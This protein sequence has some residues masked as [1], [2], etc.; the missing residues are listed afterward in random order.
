MSAAEKL[1]Q[2][3]EV[4]CDTSDREEWLRLRVDG[5]GA[6]EISM[7][8]G[9]APDAW[10][11]AVSLYAQK[12]GAYE[13]NLDD[14]EAVFWGNKLEL[15]IIE[16][17]QERTGRRTRKEGFLLR[18]KLYPWALCT[19]DGRT[20]EAANENS[21]WPL[22]VKNVSG[23]K[24]GEWVD[25]P[26]SYYYYQLQQQLLV[27]GEPKGTI[28]ALLGGQRMV[29]ADVPRDDIAIRRIIN[30][31]SAF[32]ERV[33]RRD[34]PMPD[35]SEGTRKALGA[36]YPK[37]SGVVVLPYSAIEAAD[38]IERIRG[39]ISALES[40]KASIE[41]TVRAALGDA[42]IGAMTDGRSWSWKLQTRRETVVAASSFR[43]LR[44]H[45]PKNK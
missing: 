5:I 2:P 1:D 41:N 12:I 45:Q 44:L 32:W 42:E 3:Y 7:V 31:G 11:S 37:G 35:G 9:E 21:A 33:Q 18:S 6:S 26:P 29:W 34:V 16:A 39:E 23:Y 43:V 27:T 38:E 28:A 24:A 20:W 25:G 19:L 30:Q 15:P 13:R 14:V 22:E 17:Y 8:L 36:L 40:R 4:I 10:G